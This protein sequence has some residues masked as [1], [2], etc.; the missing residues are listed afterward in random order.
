[1]CLGFQD[2]ELYLWYFYEIGVTCYWKSL[3]KDN[4]WKRPKISLRCLLYLCD[5]TELSEINANLW[6]P[7]QFVTHNKPTESSEIRIM[8]RETRL[9]YSL[10]LQGLNPVA[11]DFY[12]LSLTG[13]LFLVHLHSYLINKDRK[14]PKISFKK[15]IYI[16]QTKSHNGLPASFSHKR[17][18]SMAADGE[19][20]WQDCNDREGC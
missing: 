14:A 17:L 4:Y 9:Q 6:S 8:L 20:L 7:I 19:M 3:I 1:M 10:T 15:Y 18:L 16:D 12:C 5:S 2:G 11:E 13:S